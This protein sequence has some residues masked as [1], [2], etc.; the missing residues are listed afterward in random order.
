MNDLGLFADRS[1]HDADERLRADARKR[2][3]QGLVE[4]DDAR[5]GEAERLL[6]VEEDPSVLESVARNAG[7]AALRRIALEKLQRPGLLA[8][9]ALSDPDGEIRLW[10][11]SRI[12]TESALK[13]VMEQS[14]KTDKRVYRAASALLEQ[15]AMENGDGQAKRQHS[16]D[17]C[18]RMEG[19]L[20]ELPTDV[21]QQL[22]AI[23]ADW[24][25]LKTDV[26]EAMQRRVEGLIKAL[27]GALEA[28]D[29]KTVEVVSEALDQPSESE[30]VPEEDPAPTAA[31]PA[32]PAAAEA[33]AEVQD[34]RLAEIIEQIEQAAED[35]RADLA[36]VSAALEAHVST[37]PADVVVLWRHEAAQAALRFLDHLPAA[38]GR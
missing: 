34:P 5:Q 16:L 36:P 21:A 13:R 24:N 26:D 30:P 2:F 12:D 33:P 23:E 15:R 29:G 18:T 27:H 32:E 14:R 35:G 1:R 22:S 37:D 7:R 8:D 10:L 28:I 38:Q 6:R 20:H 25:G 17:L 11:V 31:E 3:V 4:A 9:C 19:L